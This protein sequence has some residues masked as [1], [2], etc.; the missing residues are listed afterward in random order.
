[1]DNQRHIK[2]LKDLR[3]NPE[4]QI[5]NHLYQE[6]LTKAIELLENESFPLDEP[7]KPACDE[8][9]L[10]A[11]ID[12]NEYWLKFLNADASNII[13]TTSLI[14]RVRLL[15]KENRKSD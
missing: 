10:Q 3:D 4:Y 8:Q 14:N 11:K 15:E 1:M 12:E 5:N 6:S 2:H 9:I 13:H 7:V